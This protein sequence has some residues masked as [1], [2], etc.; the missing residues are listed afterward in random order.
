M[1]ERYTEI[2]RRAIF[3][4]RY[5][6]SQFGSAHIE[7]EHILLG[8]LRETQ[9]LLGAGTLEE[10]RKVVEAHYPPEAERKR[11][12]TSIDLPL[13]GDSKRAL[14]KAAGIAD[15]MGHRRIGPEHLALGLLAEEQCLAA[16]ILRER[17]V[18]AD[19]V[20]AL[21]TQKVRAGEPPAGL[22]TQRARVVNRQGIEITLCVEPWGDR[23][24]MPPG[25]SVEIQASGPEGD[26]L[27]IDTRAGEV[28]VRCWRGSF[29]VLYRAGAVVGRR[30]LAAGEGT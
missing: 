8:L 11:V 18:T 27:E 22:T 2:A 6:A 10:V 19:A 5:E 15:H 16:R 28:T 1:F 30:E 9:P 23:Y 25:D 12:S 29:Y 14:H 3:F 26:C 17:G 21:A 20:R 13:S 7:T 24:P 4:A